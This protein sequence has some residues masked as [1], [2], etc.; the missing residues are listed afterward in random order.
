VKGCD[1]NAVAFFAIDP[2]PG[3]PSRKEGVTASDPIGAVVFGLGEVHIELK[4]KIPVAPELFPLASCC[5]RY[6]AP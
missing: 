2:E 6:S 5:N 1:Q 3:R 4:L